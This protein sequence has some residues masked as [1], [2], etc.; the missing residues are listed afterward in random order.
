M[1]HS[2]LDEIAISRKKHRCHRGLLLPA[3]GGVRPGAQSP[4]RQHGGFADPGRVRLGSR[5]ALWHGGWGAQTMQRVNVW[6]LFYIL[7]YGFIWFSMDSMVLYCFI[8]LFGKSEEW[9]FEVACFE[10]QPEKELQH[11][12]GR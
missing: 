7:F 5:G 6:I 2:V 1:F 8:V 3:L 9:D 11:G 12:N 4:P 10:T